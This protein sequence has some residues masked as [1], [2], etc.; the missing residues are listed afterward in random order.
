MTHTRS[1]KDMLSVVTHLTVAFFVLLFNQEFWNRK[2]IN[3]L[4][5]I[6]IEE[7]GK[8]K[9]T[10]AW[11]AFINSLSHP[12]QT[13]T[14]VEPPE[15]RWWTP[16]DTITVLHCYGVNILSFRE[17]IKQNLYNTDLAALIEFLAAEAKHPYLHPLESQ[18]Q[19]FVMDEETRQEIIKE[20]GLEDLFSHPELKEGL[21]HLC[22]LLGHNVELDLAEMQR[23]GQD[24]YPNWRAR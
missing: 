14:Q 16:E 21:S 23:N 10:P 13:T 8:K 22:A 5:E 3:D 15:P 18:L 1:I 11:A 4:W 9:T 24:P 20:E 6:A 19:F 12:R 17:R 7:A 2:S